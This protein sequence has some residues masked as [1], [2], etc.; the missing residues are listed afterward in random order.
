MRLLRRE[1]K[2]NPPKGGDA[3]LPV[4]GLQ[5]YDSGVAGIA[6]PAAIS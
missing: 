6:P 2:A 4:Y 3:K 5:A 1:A